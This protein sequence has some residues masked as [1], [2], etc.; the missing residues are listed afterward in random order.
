M[1]SALDAAERGRMDT[2]L[3]ERVALVVAGVIAAAARDARRTRLI[4]LGHDAPEGV[5]LERC[6]GLAGIDLP[7][8]G[9]ATGQAGWTSDDARAR[10]RRLAGDD[11][12]LLNPANK[13]VA[14]LFPDALAEPV[15]PLADLY[16]GQIARLA[17]GWSAPGRA[18]DL[19][20]RAGGVEA[21]DAFLAAHLD[22]RRP[23]EDSLAG[24]PEPAASE[25]RDRLAAGWWWRR[26]L[27]VVPKLGHRTLGL[28]LR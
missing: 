15:L 7:V 13:T 11:G 2:A 5:L 28:D 20:E 22:E 26:R 12:L 27:G 16:A 8:E 23:L 3:L 19:F 6:L 1:T 18:R 24:V 21:V 14:V 17:G 9:V 10:A 25:L 4:V